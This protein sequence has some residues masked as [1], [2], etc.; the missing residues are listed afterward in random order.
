MSSEINSKELE[1]FLFKDQLPKQKLIT[2]PNLIGLLGS[3][4]SLLGL[5]A[6]LIYFKQEII[7]IIYTIFLV[8]LVSVLIIYSI[9]REFSKNHMYAQAIFYCHYINHIIRDFFGE[10]ENLKENNLEEKITDILSAIT[11]CYSLITGK[12]CR[13][14]LRE[15]Q[16]DKTIKIRARCRKS[17]IYSRNTDYEERTFPLKENLPYYNLW[18]GK[19]GCYRYYFCN[20]I[21]R[22]YKE[23]KFTSSAFEKYGK[24]Y[25]SNLLGISRVSNWKLPYRS[26]IITPIRFLAKYTPPE[27]S[28]QGVI[29]AEWNY[30]GFLSIDCKSKNVFDERFATELGLAFSDLLYVLFNN[31]YFMKKN[32]ETEINETND[33]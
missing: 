4:C 5:I 15:F 24:P 7:S 19:S 11:E 21:I 1:T 16:E 17:K 25:V 9:W 13:T 32:E 33:S 2:L 26:V 8:F 3:I 23:H 14:T 10:F 29:P 18:Y 12:Q 27:E 20:N 30:W 6:S 22:A 31:A 28:K